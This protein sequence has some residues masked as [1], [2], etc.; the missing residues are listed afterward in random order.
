MVSAARRTA[1]WLVGHR[2]RLRWVYEVLGGALLMPYFLVTLIIW[3]TLDVPAV[4]RSPL[5]LQFAAYLLALPLVAATAFVPP[6]RP[7]EAAAAHMLLG[8]EVAPGP[9]LSWSSRWRAAVWYVLH[10][11]IG[12]LVAGASL[13]VPPAAALLIVPPLIGRPPR[14][15]ANGAVIDL[16]G[17]AGW[18]PLIGLALLVGLVVLAAVGG[19][20]LAWLAGVLLRPTVRERLANL[21][22]RAA[23]LA[24]RNRLARELHDS[25]GHALSVVTIQA[26]AAGRV[27]SRDP[28]FARQALAAVE[29]TARDALTDLDHVLGLLREEPAGTAPQPTLADLDRLLD[30]TRSTGIEVDSRIAAEAAGVPAVVSREAYRI[31]QEGL[32]NVLRHAGPVPVF[33]RVG[34]CGQRLEVELTNPVAGAGPARPPDRGRRGLVG[35]AERVAALHGQVTAGPDGHGHWR[36]A[37]EIPL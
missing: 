20:G 32:T 25:V 11:A 2:A 35:V 30:R 19:T 10:L 12:T 1:Q 5:L 34:L 4:S 37:V 24:E 3:E 21:E 26:G 33:L 18:A 15:S 28:E 27:L 8:V 9:G 31:V 29:K 7:L 17:A 13:A 22:Q 23:Q 16:S 36:L 14:M 6:V